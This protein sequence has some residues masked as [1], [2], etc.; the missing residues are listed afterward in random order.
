MSTASPTSHL[1]SVEQRCLAMV[2]AMCL[3][4]E[5]L[6]PPTGQG[7]SWGQWWDRPWWP[8]Q[9]EPMSTAMLHSSSCCRCPR[10]ASG[11]GRIFGTLLP[12]APNQSA[13]QGKEQYK[14]VQ[15]ETI[16]IILDNDPQFRWGAAIQCR[17]WTSSSR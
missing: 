1:T 14:T 2:S 5:G 12:S 13:D 16:M 9:P 11:G 10:W 15:R 3:L 8:A 7:H 17:I 4:P 6:Q